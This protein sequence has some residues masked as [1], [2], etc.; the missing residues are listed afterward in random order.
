MK[1]LVLIAAAMLPVAAHAG[2]FVTEEPPVRPAPSTA[3]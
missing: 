1:K 3:V 2:F